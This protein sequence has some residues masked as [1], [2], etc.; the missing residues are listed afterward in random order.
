MPDN[1]RMNRIV[2]RSVTRFSMLLLVCFSVSSIHAATRY[3]DISAKG[4]NNG[5]S[6]TDAWNTLS[7]SGLSAGDTVYISGGPSGGTVTYN[8]AGEFTSISGFKMGTVG[9]PVTYKIG[10]D[11]SHNGTVIFKRTTSGSQFVYGGNYYV[12]SGDAGDGKRHFKLSDYYQLLTLAGSSD[13]RISYIDCGNAGGFGSI[14]PGTNIEL[15]NCYLYSTDLSLDHGLY[16]AINQGNAYDQTRI[17]DNTINI[18]YTTGG[19]GADGFQ[20]VGSGGWSLY[21]NTVNGFSGGGINHQDGWQG[22]GGSYIK[23]YNNR[24]TNMQNYAIFAE[25]YTVGGT[26]SHVRIYNNVC[27]LTSSN[28]TQAIALSGSSSLPVTDIVC[29]NNTADG[30]ALPYTFRYP[31]GNASSAFINCVFSNN[32]SVNGGSNIID[33]AVSAASNV[34]ITASQG[35]SY[36]V[37]YSANSTANDYHLSSN[38]TTLLGKGSDLSSYF[39]IDLSGLLRISGSWDIGAYSSGSGSGSSTL[40]PSNAKIAISAQ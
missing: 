11:A 29:A 18:P 39:T 2:V 25:G 10:Q 20:I 4:A 13:V 7:F 32:L 17:H 36:F 34:A 19:I 22:S 1:A 5:T 40:P 21:N 37:K 8:L 26:Y 33:P 16:A 28:N 23:I 38:A 12:I 24:F 6:W 9:N 3:V 30:Y 27:V 15:D 35:S 31:G 14:N